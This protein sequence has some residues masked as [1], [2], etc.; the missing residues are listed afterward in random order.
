MSSSAS[1]RRPRPAFTL[2]E[3]LVVIAII[4][5]LIGLLLPAIQKARESANRARCENNLKQLALAN[6]NYADAK[7]SLP[8]GLTA[9]ASTYDHKTNKY[10]GT[11][12]DGGPR[13]KRMAPDWAWTAFVL[14]YMEQTSIY[15]QL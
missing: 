13:A 8:P 10:D 2:V 14:P 11:P 7:G 3:L 4:G 6:H 15:E 5:I 12:D 1:V 9:V